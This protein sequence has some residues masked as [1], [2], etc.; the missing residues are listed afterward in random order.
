MGLPSGHIVTELDEHSGRTVWSVRHSPLRKGLTASGGGDGAVRLWGGV[1]LEESAGAL[2]CQCERDGSVSASSV[3]CVDWSPQHCDVLVAALSDGSLVTWDVRHSRRPL[4]R[5]RA[6]ARAASYAKFFGGAHCASASIDGTLQLWQ[7]PAGM[8]GD[9]AASAP[10]HFRTFAGHANAKNFVGLA[11]LP[12]EGL[13]AT[14]SEDGA[15][16]VYQQSWGVPM[17]RHVLDRSALGAIVTAV[18]WQP[19]A[20]SLRC[21]HGPTLASATSD[22]LVHLVSLCA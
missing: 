8:G 20:A 4:M 15:A 7:L 16:H 11:V 3:C 14:G 5:W 6:H 18:A 1:H 19:L 21:G 10:D 9:A 22:G 17:V 2:Q 13:M 12:E